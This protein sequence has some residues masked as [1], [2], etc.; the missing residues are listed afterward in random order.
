[1]ETERYRYFISQI[2]KFL[3]SVIESFVIYICLMMTVGYSIIKNDLSLYEIKFIFSTTTV[4]F[5]LSQVVSSVTITQGNILSMFLLVTL[6]SFN[7]F[8][9]LTVIAFMTQTYRNINQSIVLMMANPLYNN[10]LQ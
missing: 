6:V 10:V 1:M 9:L 2:I 7:I 4:R 8:V 3:T 5:L